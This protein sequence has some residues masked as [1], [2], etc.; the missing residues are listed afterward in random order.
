MSL[1][2]AA[3]KT[4][5]DAWHRVAS[6]R[7]ELRS[8]VTSHRQFFRGEPWVILRDRFSSD[9]YR[10]SPAAY[11][12]LC[13][14]SAQ[15]T[16]A[17]VW[18]ACLE[19]DP[20]ATLTQE[21]VVQ[22]IGQMNLANLIQVDRGALSASLFERF[23]K[24]MS[25]ERKAFLLGFMSIK[26]PLL[27]P[28]QWLERA[29]TPI[30]W[31]FSPLGLL[32][33]LWLLLWGAKA[34]MDNSDRLFDQS[35]ALLAPSNLGL[36]YVGFLIAKLLH[37]LGHAALCKRFGGEVHKLGVMFLIFAPM[38]YVD[39][40]SA[41]GLRSRTERIL[42]GLGG[43]LVEL[44]VAATA[45]LVWAHSAPGTVHALAYNIMFVAS[46]S[47][48]VFNLN[49]LLRFDGYHLL[50]DVLDVPNLFQRSREQLRYLGEHFLLRLP[51]AQG[52]ARTPTEAWLLPLYGLASI[53]YWLALMST[54][55]VFVAGQYLELGILLAFV[56][57]FTS[58][59]LPLGKFVMYL[60]HSP[61]LG[62][63]RARA[64]SLTSAAAVAVLAI[65]T[66]VPVPDRV[67]VPGVL[68]AE[69]SRALHSEADGF[70]VELLA[71]PG[72][73]V[74]QDQPLLRLSNRDL[75][76][77]IEAAQMRRE[78][79]VA[80]E[81]RAISKGLVD[82]APLARQR[83]ALD[84]TLTQ[85][86]ARREAL[87]VRAPIGGV[88]S[89]SELDHTRGQW[90]T[91]GASLGAVVQGGGWRFVA[92]L[93]QIGSHVFDGEL[94]MAEVRLRGEEGLNL[95][96]RQTRVLPFEQGTLPSRALGMAGGGAIAVSPSDPH[97][98][99]AAEPFFRVEARLESGAAG[100][101]APALVHGRTGVMRMTLTSRPLL[102]Q[103]ERELRQFLQRRFRV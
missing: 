2:Q 62:A 85:L 16:I 103:W 72:E 63:Y 90:V 21:E 36:L 38:P 67:R 77:E 65:L 40:T 100:D 74:Q 5:S 94:Q 57:V 4:Y 43:V 51:Q 59:L 3:S 92:V 84:E 24:R 82:Y 28:D 23:S 54:I 58:I 34:L 14:L 30:R 52:A 99:A 11:D 13:R 66:L 39:A 50:V 12:F 49:P 20:H 26:L 53:G 6:V 87:L 32:V 17:E 19:A 42:V 10:I 88:W 56:L 48:L 27:D 83:Q 71:R 76:R 64:I 18:E 98:L 73:L 61:R 93:P 46:V 70:F 22:L 68:E 91:R 75:E 60:A 37:E 41:W 102:V 47:T 95:R 80:Q 29:R 31:L 8:S 33:Y 45:A 7:A 101:D 15:Q 55:V 35:S 44:A 89:A 78:E 96:S 97:G 25:A 69:R 81:I 9:W 86:L 79:L 1:E